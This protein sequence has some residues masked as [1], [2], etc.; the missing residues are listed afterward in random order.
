MSF[1]WT[2]QGEEETTTISIWHCGQYVCLV[3]E[4]Y[5]TD[6][7]S[8]VARII[9]VERCKQLHCASFL[10]FVAK[11]SR[12]KPD[13]RPKLEPQFSRGITQKFGAVSFTGT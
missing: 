13:K 12:K 1:F 8:A 9:P 5:Q 6:L 11:V 4:A 10:A 7:D 3:I 2:A